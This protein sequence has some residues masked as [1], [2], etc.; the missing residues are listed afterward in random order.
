[1]DVEP[2]KSNM[3]QPED[4]VAARLAGQPAMNDGLL[5]ADRIAPMAD[6]EWRAR[7]D[8]ENA[9]YAA[10]RE[11]ERQE[12]YDLQNIVNRQTAMHAA[13]ML[14]PKPSD[15]DQLVTAASTLLAF[16]TSKT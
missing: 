9:E 1:M 15:P 16:L 10:E 7:R 4:V 5:G 11:R 6:P 14:E 12:R 8:A 3:P 2:A 13:L